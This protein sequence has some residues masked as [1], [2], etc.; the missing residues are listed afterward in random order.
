M[1]QLKNLFIIMISFMLLESFIFVFFNEE[2]KADSG[3]I[4][5][6]SSYHG[7]SDG[8]AEKPF[9]NINFAIDLANEGDTI[10]V[11]G[12]YYDE[13]LVID[14]KLKLWGS[15]ENGLSIIDY[16][17]D[18]RYTVEINADYVEMQNFDIRD[19]E[20]VKTSPIGALLCVKS[21]NVALQGNNISNS[22]SWGI[23]LA[24]E[25]NGNVISGNIIK[26]V[27]NGIYISS[28]STNDI[29]NNV[30][31]NC[32]EKAINIESSQNNRFY[33]NIVN[34]NMF[35]IYAK[36][37]NNINITN[38]TINASRYQG[39]YLDQIYSGPIKSNFIN[40]AKFIK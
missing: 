31:E 39:L 9:K 7:F 1:K 15:V 37:C 29:F 5:V 8:S 17:E 26:S 12:G 30:I 18:L 16:S 33:G 40:K 38:N 23:Y 3:E 6:D 14:K 19:N 20:K 25:S 36:N 13:A 2:C 4:Y 28:S 11:F 24:P 21:N 35:G 34:N 22:S 27:E 10:Y 32:S